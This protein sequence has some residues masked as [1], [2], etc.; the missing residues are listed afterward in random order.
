MVPPPPL[1]H[2]PSD[3]ARA[4]DE[5]GRQ[6]LR[7]SSFRN[8]AP[9]II[10][11][12]PTGLL[13]QRPLRSSSFNLDEG[14]RDLA[15]QNTAD[16]IV[17]QQTR[18]NFDCIESADLPRL[19]HFGSEVQGWTK[20]SFETDSSKQF[21]VLKTTRDIWLARK[22]RGIRASQGC[23]IISPVKTDQLLGARLFLTYC[24]VATESWP[25]HY[26]ERLPFKNW[27]S[28]YRRWNNTEITERVC[29]FLYSYSI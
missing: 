21:S 12:A 23:D 2:A 29:G 26:S 28:E 6:S 17:P 10:S 16:Y 20:Q 19:R 11:R 1:R 3:L 13:V 14:Q 24:T 9:V 25:T 27:T 22:Y 5:V 7:V 8:P 15:I 18:H 4:F